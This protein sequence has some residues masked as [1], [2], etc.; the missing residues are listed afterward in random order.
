[1]ASANN[2]IVN[3]NVQR[4]KI[5]MDVANG[6]V[7]KAEIRNICSDKVVRRSFIGNKYSNKTDSS[8]WDNEYLD[9]V[10]CASVAENFNEDYLMYLSDVGTYVRNKKDSGLNMK[11]VIRAVAIVA[12]IVIMAGIVVWKIYNSGK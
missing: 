2:Y 8:N 11:V 4:S 7:S 6:S 5:A 9:K 10:V 1:M 3:G 12:V